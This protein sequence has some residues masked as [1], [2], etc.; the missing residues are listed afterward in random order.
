MFAAHCDDFPQH[1]LFGEVAVGQGALYF[2]LVLGLVDPGDDLLIAVEP[3]HGFCELE[4]AVFA[5]EGCDC[6]GEIAQQ[7]EEIGEKIQLR[8]SVGESVV[9]ELDQEAD[10]AEFVVED[11]DLG[12]ARQGVD[13]PLDQL[14]DIL[15]F[16][17]PRHHQQ[18]KLLTCYTIRELPPTPAPQ[19]HPLLADSCR[20]LK[21]PV[22]HRHTANIIT[23]H[24][25]L[26]D[27]LLP[28]PSHQT[29]PPLLNGGTSAEL[30]S[31]L[32]FPHPLKNWLF[33][34]ALRIVIT[35]M[36]LIACS[37]DA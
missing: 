4:I 5:A 30:Y 29:H 17:Q 24:L 9:V 32:F 31:L 23:K 3:D 16:F 20:H 15:W 28:L 37:T 6:E 7:L 21:L 27:Q 8:K 10:F 19:L 12:R 34:G 13:R 25:S 33:R 36:G 22:S 1:N 2:G 11:D 14:R 18:L 35:K 26:F